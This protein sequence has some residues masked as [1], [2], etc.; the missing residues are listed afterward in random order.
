MGVAD[1]M[2]A[3]WQSIPRRVRMAFILWLPLL[4]A[5]CMLALR[6]LLLR[7]GKA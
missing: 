7:S 2:K 6:F 3:D 1:A 5:A 4:L